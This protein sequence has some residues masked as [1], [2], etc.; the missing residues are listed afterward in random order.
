MCNKLL[1]YR[2]KFSGLDNIT[3]I[4]IIFGYIRGER[5]Y[6]VST[7]PRN[8]PSGLSGSSQEVEVEVR[9]TVGMV[10]Y[11]GVC[12]AKSSFQAR[13]RAMLTNRIKPFIITE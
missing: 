2:L 1:S 12:A 10:F 4:S 3:S 11:P 6:S 8:R 9:S 13:P 7:F 5:K